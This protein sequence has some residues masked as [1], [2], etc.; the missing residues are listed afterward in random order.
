MSDGCCAS[1]TDTAASQVSTEVD[2]WFARNPREAF[3]RYLQRRALFESGLPANRG[4]CYEEARLV[5][6]ASAGVQRPRQRE[7]KPE[8]RCPVALSPPQGLFAQDAPSVAPLGDSNGPDAF[9]ATTASSAG[10]V[11]HGNFVNEV[12]G[13]I[14]ASC[15]CKTDEV[16]SSSTPQTTTTATGAQGDGHRK[17]T[18]SRPEPQLAPRASKFTALRSAARPAHSTKPVA[19]RPPALFQSIHMIFQATNEAISVLEFAPPAIRSPQRLGLGSASGHV[20]IVT[21]D[22]TV[23]KPITFAKLHS[24]AVVRLSFSADGLYLASCCEDA[25]VAVREV[26]SGRCVYKFHFVTVGVSLFHP[27][28]NAVLLLGDAAH[29]LACVEVSELSNENFLSKPRLMLPNACASVFDHTG[30]VLFVATSVGTIDVLHVSQKKQWQLTL[31]QSFPLQPQPS[32]TSSCC[33][34]RPVAMSYEAWLHD[35][36]CP[37]L[38]VACTDGSVHIF[39]WLGMRDEYAIQGPRHSSSWWGRLMEVQ[40][41]DPLSCTLVLRLTNMPSAGVCCP[42]CFCGAA[43]SHIAWGCSQGTVSVLKLST[44]RETDQLSAHSSSITSLQSLRGVPEMLASG[45]SS[46]VVVVWASDVGRLAASTSTSDAEEEI[47]LARPE[48]HLE[49]KDHSYM[50]L[51]LLGSQRASIVFDHEDVYG[52]VAELSDPV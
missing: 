24:C 48:Q 15:S 39:A 35:F 34:H 51:G 5:F 40:S 46:G 43:A 10:S 20:M 38:L 11:A 16:S 8:S 2:G 31:W 42:V 12:T 9:G 4:A 27:A 37:G 52:S 6:S 44:Q 28:T 47:A 22:D 33:A 17:P 7:G 26:P 13:S 23:A 18:C 41:S 45:D 19:T 14:S 1:A 29:G 21:P 25:A 3:D 50:Q 30:T 49:I 36:H 32:S